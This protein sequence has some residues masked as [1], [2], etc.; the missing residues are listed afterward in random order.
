MAGPQPG[1]RG[2]EHREGRASRDHS[3]FAGWPPIE[4]NAREGDGGR[5]MPA[6]VALALVCILAAALVFGP[7][8]LNP[9]GSDSGSSRLLVENDPASAEPTASGPSV[10]DRKRV[11]YGK[12]VF[13]RLHLCCPL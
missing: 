8:L 2:W 13:V 5:W 6:P 9:T 11:V 10:Q 4:R 3:G 1:L 7:E 12:R